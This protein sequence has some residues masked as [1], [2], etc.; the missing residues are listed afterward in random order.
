MIP[1][2]VQSRPPFVAICGDVH[3]GGLIGEGEKERER[4]THTLTKI[5]PR[6]SGKAAFLRLFEI[7]IADIIDGSCWFLL[8]SPLC[9]RA[10]D[11]VKLW[12]IGSRLWF[13]FSPQ[14]TYLISASLS[15]TACFF[16][17]SSLLSV[18]YGNGQ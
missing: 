5:S 15:F 7:A 13:L 18:L 14:T 12:V 9:T 11:V 4:E 6:A 2:F 17:F 3:R 1:Y 10:A 8:H 16:C